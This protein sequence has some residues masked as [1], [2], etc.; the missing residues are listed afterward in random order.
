MLPTPAYYFILF[1]L[2]PVLPLIVWFSFQ[3]GHGLKRIAL[4]GSLVFAALSFVGMV[5]QVYLIAGYLFGED[6]LEAHKQLGKLVHLFYILTFLTALVA[7]WPNLR[8]TLWPFV[9]ASLGSI[10]A[11]LASEIHIPFP[12]MRIDL[13]GGSSVVHAFHG[14]LVPVV[15][16]IAIASA[17]QAWRELGLGV[18]VLPLGR[19]TTA[20]EVPRHRVVVVGGGFAGLQAVRKLRDAPVEVTLVDRQNFHLFQPLVYQVATGALSAAEI[21]A[22]LRAVLKHQANVHVLL[23]EVTGFD[24]ERRQVVVDRLA[25]GGGAE[26]L[27]YDTLIVA[28]GSHY[29]YFGHDEWSAHAPELKSLAGA[30]DI[31]NR[32]LTAFEAAEVEQDEE[33]RLSWLTFVVV[34]GGPTGVE[35]AGQ[36]AELARDTLRRDFRSADPRSARVLLVEAVDRMLPTFPKSLSNNAGRALTK[37]GVTPLV[38]HTVVDVGPESV[39]IRTPDGTTA[40]VPART[41]VWAAGVSASPLAAALADAAG[42]EVDRAGRL[43]VTPDLTVAGHPEVFAIGDMVSVRRSDGTTL[44]L[45]GVAPVAMQQGRYV[46]DVLRKRLRYRAW[47]PFRYRDK[48]DLATIGRSKAV[49]RLKHVRLSGF[50]AWITWLTVHLYYLVGFQNR[51]LV[52]TRWTISYFTRGRGARLINEGGPDDAAATTA[53]LPERRPELKKAARKRASRAAPRV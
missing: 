35:I 24:L 14:A 21:A 12:E 46:A 51:L 44:P 47:R 15:F 3:F 42:A 18:H 37:L 5:V 53:P 29:S 40:S 33:R 17:R 22:P 49:A 9:L 19:E 30:V 45:P 31:R 48:G 25:S 50:L 13:A 23:G 36:I 41:V 38:G 52:V 32:I 7:F 39:A 2:I 6:Y 20:Y 26:T 4:V 43:F 28:A 34:G 27:E 11:F 16:V 1:V 10:Q 8:A